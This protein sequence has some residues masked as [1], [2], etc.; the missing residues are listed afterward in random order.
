M[1]L[2]H[3]VTIHATGSQIP[4]E[5]PYYSFACSFVL[6]VIIHVACVLVKYYPHHHWHASS[7]LMGPYVVVC[8]PLQGTHQCHLPP[9]RCYCEFVILLVLLL[10]FCVDWPWWGT[11]PSHCLVHM[12]ELLHDW[13]GKKKLG[14]FSIIC[15]FL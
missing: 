14:N 1:L 2:V 3:H 6:M 11:T 10:I 9:F 12:V 8:L 7:K 4:F 15:N 13:K 5:S